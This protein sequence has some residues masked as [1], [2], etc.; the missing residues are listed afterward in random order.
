VGRF[1]GSGGTFRENLLREPE[2]KPV[3]ATHAAARL[4]YDELKN[5][6]GVEN[7]TG[8]IWIKKD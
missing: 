7:E 1:R 6:P 8:D 5:K 3:P 2:E 4:K